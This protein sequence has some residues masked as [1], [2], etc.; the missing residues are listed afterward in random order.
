[1]D[2]IILCNSTVYYLLAMSMHRLPRHGY[3]ASV[4]RVYERSPGRGHVAMPAVQP[5]PRW[6]A[7]PGDVSATIGD[8]GRCS[9]SSADRPASAAASQHQ[10]GL[11]WSPIDWLTEQCLRSPPT[12]YRLSGRRFL[13]V[14]KPNQQYQ[15]TEG[16]DAA[17][18]NPEKANNTKYS[19]KIKTHTH[20]QKLP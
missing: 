5:C 15:S 2:H 18:V 9:A 1:M 16:K 13:Q 19:N 20:T 11:S 8:D 17:K 4:G 12:Q 6:V 7:E 10:A 3:S 14:K